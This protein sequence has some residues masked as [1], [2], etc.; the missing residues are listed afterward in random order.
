MNLSREQVDVI[1][2]STARGYIQKLRVGDIMKRLGAHCWT[3]CPGLEPEQWELQE[4]SSRHLVALLQKGS[5]DCIL[6]SLY[7]VSNRSGKI[8]ICELVTTDN[9]L[10]KRL[11]F[12]HNSTIK[13]SGFPKSLQGVIP[14]L[15]YVF[16]MAAEP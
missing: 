10:Y 16:N 6:T 9:S 2:C 13:E 8:R 15:A 14:Y 5:L 12:N 11:F 3:F 7:L 1:K 4:L